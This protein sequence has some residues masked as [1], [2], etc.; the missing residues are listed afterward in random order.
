MRSGMRKGTL[1]ASAWPK[2]MSAR[3]IM[4]T[5]PQR[6]WQARAADSAKGKIYGECLAVSPRGEVGD[7]ASNRGG[8]K[9]ADKIANGGAAQG[10][11]RGFAAGE[12]GQ[13]DEAKAEE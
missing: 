1:T 4:P 3:N 10:R 9:V 13:A 8:Y 6:Y 5:E 7:T 2:D 11:E 12:H